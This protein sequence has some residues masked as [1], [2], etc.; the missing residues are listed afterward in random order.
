MPSK[1]L[2]S[3]IFFAATMFFPM[4]GGVFSTAAEAAYRPSGV[5]AKHYRQWRRKPGAKAFAVTRSGRACGLSH[6][7]PTRKQANRRALRECRK[8]SRRCRIISTRAAPRSKRAARRAGGFRIRGN[9][10][11]FYAKWKKRPGFGAFVLERDGSCTSNW[12]HR[13]ED[14]AAEALLKECKPRSSCHLHDVKAPETDIKLRQRQLLALGLYSGKIDGDW[15]RGSKAAMQRF[16]KAAGLNGPPRGEAYKR[17]SWAK[18]ITDRHDV[19][20]E[21]AI[22]ASKQAARELSTKFVREL[23]ALRKNR[24]PTKAPTETG[25]GSSDNLPDS[26]QRRRYPRQTAFEK[27]LGGGLNQAASWKH[28]SD[29]WRH[30]YVAARLNKPGDRGRCILETKQL[31]FL[32]TAP[33]TPTSARSILA[34]LPSREFPAKSTN[35]IWRHTGPTPTKSEIGSRPEIGTY[36]RIAD[37]KG[38]WKTLRNKDNVV[39]SFD[40]GAGQIRVV[41]LRKSRGPVDNFVFCMDRAKRTPVAPTPVAVKPAATGGGGTIVTQRRGPDGHFH[42]PVNINGVSTSMMFD[43][44][45]TNIA[46]TRSFAK[47]IGIEVEDKDFR[48][49]ANTANGVIN[50]AKEIADEVRVGDIVMR[51]VIVGVLRDKSLPGS[52]LLGNSFISRLEEF[53]IRGN[54]LTLDGG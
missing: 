43:T 23:I 25:S 11:K 53:R 18:T 13:S 50:Y 33:D 51:D 47:K 7:Y 35:L 14:E 38:F 6:G 19:D 54:V 44:G 15:G 17:L 1:M 36:A 31:V 34:F 41:D 42:L 24:V 32:Y 3:V 21:F 12:N 4:P 45:A 48:Y 46:I 30:R 20:A 9:C 27:E 28:S 52:A 40:G 8:H 5:C 49:R 22:E 10:R 39:V 26:D 2:L 37:A 29:H 16:M